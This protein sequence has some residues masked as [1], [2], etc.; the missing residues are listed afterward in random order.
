MSPFRDHQ[1]DK[2]PETR[3]TYLAISV[4]APYRGPFDRRKPF[5]ARGMN[6]L[7]RGGEGKPPLS[8]RRQAPRPIVGDDE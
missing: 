6:F 2:P 7:G 5:V 8:Y 4:P 1:D 3:E